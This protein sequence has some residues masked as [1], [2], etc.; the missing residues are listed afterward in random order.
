M[1]HEEEVRDSVSA[2]CGNNIDSQD[3]NILLG[4]QEGTN[5]RFAPL[6]MRRQSTDSC[7]FSRSPGTRHEQMRRMETIVGKS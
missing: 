6:K 5:T 1:F 4:L 3:L 7:R 2:M